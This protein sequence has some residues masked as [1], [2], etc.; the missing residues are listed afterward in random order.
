MGSVALVLLVLF[1][2]T[3]G[4]TFGGISLLILSKSRVP[5]STAFGWGAALG[6]IGLVVATVV[7]SKHAAL[8][9][10]SG[11]GAP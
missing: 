5:K 10:D 1:F 11:E 6:P 3:V 2:F 8:A 7:A 9:R 4:A